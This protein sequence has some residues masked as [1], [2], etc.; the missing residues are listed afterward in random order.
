MG[1]GEARGSEAL[2]FGRG[3]RLDSASARLGPSLPPEIGTCQQLPLRVEPGR[4]GAT[5]GMAGLADPEN[6]RRN[7]PFTPIAVC[8]P[9]AAKRQISPITAHPRFAYCRVRH[10]GNVCWSGFREAQE[11]E[12]R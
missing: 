4:P 7:R 9:A 12:V 11:A 10:G 6:P 5:L 2:I 1:P 8:V 3:A